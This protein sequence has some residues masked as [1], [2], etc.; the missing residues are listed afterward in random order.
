M[1]YWFLPYINM[2][3]PYMY[4]Y[5]LSFLNLLPT[6]QSIPWLYIV[7]E[8]W[9]ELSASYSKFPLA[10]YFS[11]GYIYVLVLLS[12]YAPPSPSETVSTSLF[13]TPESLLLYCSTKQVNQYNFFRFRICAV[14]Y[15]ACFSLSLTSFCVIGSRFTYLFRTD[16]NAF[17]CM[18]E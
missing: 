4:T 7:A 9:V 15:D 1:L 3:Q 16:S 13:S 5:V 6:S 2:N 18:T 17:P 11:Y 14:I 10:I 8:H 12:Q